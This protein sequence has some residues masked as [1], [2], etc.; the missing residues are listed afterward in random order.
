[1]MAARESTAL[2]PARQVSY[3]VRVRHEVVAVTVMH[4]C[5]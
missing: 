1:M 5:E 2:Q 4:F 3:V